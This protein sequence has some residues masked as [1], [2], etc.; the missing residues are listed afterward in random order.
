MKI[1]RTRHQLACRQFIKTFFAMKKFEQRENEL[2]H[3]PFSEFE[4]CLDAKLEFLKDDF[5][6]EELHNLRNSALLQHFLVK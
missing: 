4:E 6:P 2:C 1:Q 5:T 3:K